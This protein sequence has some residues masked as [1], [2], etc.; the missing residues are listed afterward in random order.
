VDLGIIVVPEK[1]VLS[2]AEDCGK[3][4]CKAL[5]VITAGFKETGSEGLRR[6]RDLVS[7]CRKY[8]MRM[9]G[10]NCV[11]LMDTHTL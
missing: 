7:I 8:N 11:G 6:E 9:L 5:I 2:V 4:G 3:A 10:P 1:A